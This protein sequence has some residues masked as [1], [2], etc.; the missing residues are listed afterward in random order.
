MRFCDE[1]PFGFSWIADEPAKRTSHA[2]ATG[3]R[4]W[5]VDPVDWPDALDRA[6]GLGEPA[7]VVQLLDRH[8]RDCATVAA[9]L[10]VPHLVT[11]TAIAD[12][13]FV[14]VEVKKSRRWHEVGLWWGE[15]RTLVVAEAIGTNDFF[16]A[17][18]DLAGVHLL[19]R[20]TPPRASLGAFEPEH[21]LVGHGEGVHGPQAA[22][23]LRAAL[24]N[25]RGGLPRQALSLP[26]LA[27]DAYRRRR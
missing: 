22:E 16:T 21:L 10:H 8:N 19:L 11:P 20:L 6:V 26:A 3:G 23:A 1:L 24:A 17:G 18:H 12:A 27:L 14:L 13:P 5:L 2:L 25:S 15:T 7:A 9:R 4:F